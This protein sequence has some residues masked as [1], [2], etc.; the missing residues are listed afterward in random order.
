MGFFSKIWKGVKKGFKKLFKPIK[1]VFKSIGKFM[2][3]IGIV[4][5]IAM[6]FIPIPGLGALM[7]SLGGMVSSAANT[8]I[9]VAGKGIGGAIA[10]GAGHVLKMAHTVGGKISQGFKTITEGVKSFVGN[11]G[12][13]LANKIPGINIEGAPTSFFG[14]G[15]ESVL[16]RTGASIN[17]NLDVLFGR[18]SVDPF[19]TKVKPIESKEVFNQGATDNVYEGYK[20]EGMPATP[21]TDFKLPDS[22]IGVEGG[23]QKSYEFQA[24]SGS[25]I[26]TTDTLNTSSPVNVEAEGLQ[27]YQD[28]TGK[29][30]SGRSNVLDNIQVKTDFGPT[31]S[32]SPRPS[33]LERLSTGVAEAP[34]KLF[35]YVTNTGEGGLAQ[36]A[37]N[38]AKEIPGKFVDSA[39]MGQIGGVMQDR[40]EAAPVGF[41]MQKDD[42]FYASQQL[43]GSVYG[44][45]SPQFNTAAN[46]IVEPMYYDTDTRGIWQGSLQQRT[47]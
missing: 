33:L 43:A 45:Q 47:A 6:M 30:V 25:S 24:S 10:R 39:I 3:K 8:L 20:A 4:G 35:D 2:N 12:K 1:S 15:S 13:Y 14:K 31:M 36:S 26:P 18:P 21:G 32:G 19:A 34:G 5:Q 23:V 16:G 38:K 22:G 11:T 46:Y 44:A 17:K 28:S 7:S 27:L 29:V 41:Y 40:P 37:Y 42:S 9:G